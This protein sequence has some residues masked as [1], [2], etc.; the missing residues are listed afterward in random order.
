[1]S[2]E[3]KLI[4]GQ[5]RNTDQKRAEATKACKCK[6][7]TLSLETLNNNPRKSTLV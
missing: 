2:N 7:G 6:S 3:L 1:M 5:P 4:Q